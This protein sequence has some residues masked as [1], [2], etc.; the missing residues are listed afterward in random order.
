MD[1][2][3]L[4]SDGNRAREKR[5]YCKGTG[6]TA[7]KSRTARNPSLRGAAVRQTRRRGTPP[8]ERGQPP[9]LIK[10]GGASAGGSRCAGSG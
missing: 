6:G 2:R 7:R 5:G 1:A 3:Y 9:P 4:T 10:R 8:P